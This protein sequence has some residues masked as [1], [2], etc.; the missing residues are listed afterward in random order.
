[1]WINHSL[2]VSQFKSKWDHFLGLIWDSNSF[3]LPFHFIFFIFLFSQLS[4]KQT[5]KLT[6]H[7]FVH[8]LPF[9]L[10]TML[11]HHD[12]HPGKSV[13]CTSS[14]T[15]GMGSLRC[16]TVHGNENPIPDMIA[17]HSN[18]NRTRT[19]Y[20]VAKSST[21]LKFNKIFEAQRNSEATHCEQQTNFREDDQ[22]A[23][24]RLPP[25]LQEQILEVLPEDFWFR[26][27]H[28]SRRAWPFGN[29]L[30]C[31]CFDCGHQQC[32]PPSQVHPYQVQ[33]IEVCPDF[34]RCSPPSRYP[35]SS[36]KG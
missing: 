14:V 10:F 7:I 18:E 4:N 25:F 35:H 12:E 3:A 16:T 24:L 2:S 32:W 34:Q 33:T 5:H 11:D 19:K 1:M 21:D 27:L 8:T 6:L 23:R 17:R 31:C 28:S 13:V 36:P 26:R 30:G 29:I 22:L 20:L 15:L 9:R